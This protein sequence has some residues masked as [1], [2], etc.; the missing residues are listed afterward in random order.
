MDRIRAIIADD[1]PL[2][3]RGIRQLL[4]AH[5]D[6]NIVAEAR[7]GQEAVHAL[8][9]FRPDLIFLDVQ[10]PLLD[11]FDVLRE[12]GAKAMPAVIFVT[13]YDEFAVRAFA[14]HALDYLVKPLEEERFA[15]AVERM[16]EQLRTAKA[17]GLS[18]RLTALLAA[19]AAAGGSQR[20]LVP[21]ANGDLVLDAN[22]IDWIAAD[23]YYAAIHARRGRHLLRESLASLEQRLD[24]NR[25][26]RTHRSAIVNIDRV[27]ELRNE[28]GATLLVLSSG[29]RVPVS[30]RC[31]AQVTKLL[32]ERATGQAKS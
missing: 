15:D 20:I 23:D 24:R 4:A 19:R 13:A 10:M 9:E 32:R 6:I 11:G 30:R 7:N 14:A 21:T 8:R 5:R 12:I 18:Q 1:E 16:R 17:A 25:F 28:R 31:R 29:V 22:E 27:S 26:V 3:R 2:A